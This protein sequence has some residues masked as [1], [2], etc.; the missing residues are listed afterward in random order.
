MNDDIFSKIDKDKL[1]KT[2]QMLKDKLGP[3]DAAKVD[4]A[5]ADTAMINKMTS[6]MSQKDKDMVVRLVN[7][8]AAMKAILSSPKA[9]ELIKQFMNKR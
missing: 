2:V 8:P 1:D 7:N 9:A 6:G 4:A 5:L 3:A